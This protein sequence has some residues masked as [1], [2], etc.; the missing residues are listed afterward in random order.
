M[1]E[2][3]AISTMETKEEREKLTRSSFFVFCVPADG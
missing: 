3:K 1:I 2:A